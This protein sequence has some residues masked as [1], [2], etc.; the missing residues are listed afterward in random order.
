METPTHRKHNRQPLA[1]TTNIINNAQSPSA[2][3][4]LQ[5]RKGASPAHTPDNRSLK[6]GS[7]RPSNTASPATSTATDKRLSALINEDHHNTKRDSQVSTSSAGSAGRQVKRYVGPWQI[8][9]SIAMGATGRVRKARHRYTGEK[10]A[11]KILSRHLAQS[12]SV[13]A[14]DN[15]LARRARERQGDAKASRHIPMGIEREIIIMKLI[16]HPCVIRFLDIWENRNELYLFIEEGESGE[17]FKHIQENKVLSEYESVRI[18]RQIISALEYCHQ[19]SI[20]HRDLKPE[21][22]L[23]DSIGNVKIADFGMATLQLSGTRLETSCGSAHYVCPERATYRPYQGDLSDIWSAGVILYVMLSGCLPF[24]HSC[25]E[26]DT[27]KILYEVAHAPI[28]YPSWLSMEAR[29]LISAILQREP[30]KRMTLREMWNHPL[31]RKYEPYARDPKYAPNWVGGPVKP[32]TEAN[33]GARLYNKRDVDPDILRNVLILC[34]TDQED[35]IINSLISANANLEKVFYNSL[36]KFRD[37][38]LENYDGP[39]ISSSASDYHHIVRPIIRRS[40]TRLSLQPPGHQRKISHLSSSFGGSMNRRKIRP[41]SR[42]SS[43]AATEQSYDPFKHSR[44]LD[45]RA[46][47]EYARI[48]LLGKTSEAVRMRSGSRAESARHSSVKSARTG[49]V[50]PSSP[51]PLP[52]LYERRRSL[53]KSSGIH[54]RSQSRSS[55]A[56]SHRAPSS[57]RVARSSM[58]YKRGVSFVRM[59]KLSGGETLPPPPRAQAPSPTMMAQ[60]Y[61]NDRLPPTSSSSPNLPSPILPTFSQPEEE[62]VARSQSVRPASTRTISNEGQSSSKASRVSAL[63]KE[64]AKHFSSELGKFCDDVFGST[65]LTDEDGAD[66]D[67]SFLSSSKTSASLLSEPR[68]AKP[69][70]RSLREQYTDARSQIATSTIGKRPLPSPIGLRREL[71]VSQ[72]QR[73]LEATLENLRRQAQNPDTGLPPGTLDDVISTLERLRAQNEGKILGFDPD[74]RPVSADH[75]L[76]LSPVKE[77]SG[78]R[79]SW[80]TI[81]TNAADNPS[82][83]KRAGLVGHNHRAV[84][85]PVHGTPRRKDQGKDRA[86][87]GFTTND[88]LRPSIRVVNHDHKKPIS[89]VR[90][91]NIRKSSAALSTIATAPVRGSSKPRQLPNPLQQQQHAATGLRI[92]QPD[93]PSMQYI[94]ATTPH[95]RGFDPF[96]GPLSSQIYRDPSL[97]RPSSQAVEAKDASLDRFHGTDDENKGNQPPRALPPRLTEPTVNLLNSKKS[98]WFSRRS[99][100]RDT[101]ISNSTAGKSSKSGERGP[102]PPMKDNW[103]LQEREV[104]ELLTQYQKQQQEQRKLNEQARN[105][106]GAST[107]HSG[108]ASSHDYNDGA[109]VAEGDKES[110]GKVK[111]NA[112]KFFTKIFTRKSSAT[113]NTFPRAL[114]SGFGLASAGDE[115]GYFDEDEEDDDAESN[116]TASQAA[117]RRGRTYDTITARSTSTL[118]TCS[119]ADRDNR[120]KTQQALSRTYSSTTSRQAAPTNHQS[121]HNTEPFHNSANNGRPSSESISAFLAQ[122]D[123]SSGPVPSNRHG[124]GPSKSY[125]GQSSQ[126]WL[127]RLLHIKP[128]VRTIC[129]SAE[130]IKARKEVVRVLREWKRFGMESIAVDKGNC[131]VWG[132]VGERNHLSIKPVTFAVQLFTVLDQGRRANLSI[133]RLSQEKGA[134]SSFE[135]VVDALV[136]T[137][138]HRGLLIADEGVCAEMRDVLG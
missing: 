38:Q 128:A 99:D 82:P 105:N 11:V 102:T 87:T 8:G 77:E 85:A 62:R 110:V 50:I 20:C 12:Q 101:Q 136:D 42:Q 60:K 93:P 133:A 100:K 107:T 65:S 112:K 32:L 15:V 7:A 119:R 78:F 73:Q 83:R 76:L 30:R 55:L 61:A 45:P 94:K 58:S 17:L 1:D 6:P 117:S 22:I 126:S 48:T 25:A 46:E 53:P 95:V 132:R 33:C 135:R 67:E 2:I 31:L 131:R 43:I 28:Q 52:S 79:D 9:K 56:S 113:E 40:S 123:R 103:P 66:R 86:A 29:D 88:D 34:R 14:L 57:L 16:E 111:G 124:H 21:N 134:K 69:A 115:I 37:E 54:A 92:R 138:D 122:R 13:L 70:E 51:P 3:G 80:Q 4:N 75:R 84:S 74:R 24:G 96:S 120:R 10:A 109:F 89:P 106:Q 104:R 47:A 98:A 18:F 63:W 64:D 81:Q 44:C 127:A 27:E 36:R 91:L 59:R 68:Y 49:S 137:L 71:S 19:F 97:E 130:R 118:A 116:A 108:T 35:A 114:R 121:R 41:Q 39:L 129:F 5:T 90:P 125:Y 26:N 72:T 23:L